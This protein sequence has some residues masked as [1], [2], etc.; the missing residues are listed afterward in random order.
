[1]ISAPAIRQ[2]G[3]SWPARLGRGLVIAL[4]VLFLIGR[5]PA[6][7]AVSLIAVLLLVRSALARD[8]AWLR[9]PWV[10][11]GLAIWLYLVLV[12]GLAADA[13]GAYSRAMPFGRFV[14]FGAALQHWLLVER[15]TR[16]AMLIALAAVISVVVLD[17]LFQYVHGQDILGRDFQDN[18]LTGPFAATVPG[19]FLSKTWLPVLGL[20]LALAAPWSARWRNALVFGLILLLALTIT[21][22]GERI[23]LA[24]L[25]LGLVPFFL[26]L[27]EL[28]L[29]LLL[30]GLAALGLIA[31]SIAL[32]P[33]LRTR[34]IRHT[35]Y[36]MNDFWD[37]RYGEP[38]RRSV[39]IWHD[40]PVF[41]IGLRNF[42]HRCANPNFKPIGPVE[43][44][45]YTHP[46]QIYLEWLVETGAVGFLGFL[47]MI[48]LWS[49]DLISGLITV[50]RRD[51]PIAVGAL[52]ALLVFLWP[53]RSSMSFFSNWNAILF[54]LMLGLS[55]ALCAPRGAAGPRT[56]D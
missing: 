6:D 23:A 12:S 31:G 35:A 46:H 52:A 17:S 24:T 10:I 21:L 50:E 25:G 8:W 4:P 33:D 51:Y 30:A 53:L 15:G 47:A 13:A 41:G 34:L 42:R 3:V 20:A 44:R 14:L 56:D 27:R 40:Q 11:A 26:L 5:A 54:W 38:F 28:R 18:R 19:S 22:T 29:P 43:D 48:G 32:S 7:I 49:R 1:M 37:K 16:R 39:R 45:C 2:A 36:D 9:T 55:L